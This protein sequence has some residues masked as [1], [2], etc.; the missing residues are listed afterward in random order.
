MK[1]SLK[2][3]DKIPF[4][5]IAN[6]VLNDKKLSFKAKGVFGYLYSK[7]DGWDF[8]ADRISK[9]SIDGVKS[10]SASLKELE[11][12]G[13]LSRKRQHG[14][15]V[16]Y[17]ISFSANSQNGILPKRHYAKTG[18]LSNTDEE[19]NKEGEETKN[20]APEVAVSL[21]IPKV[22]SFF[23]KAKPK[24]D[25]MA[26]SLSQF[27]LMCRGS[28]NRNIRIIGE[29]ADAREDD[30]DF[31]TCGQWRAFGN[32]NMTV[33]KELAPFTDHQIQ[34]ALNSVHENLK[35][36]GGFIA[37]WGLETLKKYLIK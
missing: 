20:S 35:E 3:D 37:N 29:Y 25:G 22:E 27:I 33:A 10:V 18:Q 36:N 21:K 28:A 1:E 34:E 4:T 13:Y 6:S 26:M 11:K 17:Q 8:S 7:P 5:Q 14:G 12:Q 2:K 16:V 32:R 30:L 19:S 9:D 15:R 24:T 23:G 31:D